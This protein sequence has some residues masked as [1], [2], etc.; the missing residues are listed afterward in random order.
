MLNI[1]CKYIP[2]QVVVISQAPHITDLCALVSSIYF[3]FFW[4]D[5]NSSLVSKGA[6]ETFDNELSGEESDGLACTLLVSSRFRGSAE[7]PPE[8]HL[9]PNLWLKAR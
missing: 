6:P 4:A 7:W 5:P 2:L 8:I 1:Y 9:G 3:S